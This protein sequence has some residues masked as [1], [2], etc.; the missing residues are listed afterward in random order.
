MLGSHQGQNMALAITAFIEVAVALKI[1]VS[2]EKIQVAIRKAKLAG[3]FEEVLPNVY[4]DG[5]HN[6]ASIRT[7]IDTVK[8]HFPT[9][10]IEFVLGILADKEVTE[11]LALLEEISDTFYFVTIENDRAMDAEKMY[12][13]SRA[14]NKIIVDDV[15][16][17]LQLQPIDN[18]VRIVTGSLYLLSEIRRNLHL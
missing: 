17:L 11:I 2:E 13:L 15:I 7:L 14:N 12:Q 18:C 1:P 16:Q 3:R 6:P 10:K 4:F 9:K 8:K 5:A